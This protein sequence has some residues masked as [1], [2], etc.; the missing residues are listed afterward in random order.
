M[1]DDEDQMN[2]PDG[3]KG[4]FLC[5]KKK[6][7][8]V[9]CLNCAGVF[10]KSCVL[11]NKNYEVVSDSLI[12]C[13]QPKPSAEDQ[14][15]DNLNEASTYEVQKLKF[16]NL[17]LK[18]L[19]EASESKFQLLQNN[20]KLLEENKKLLEEKVVLIQKEFEINTKN[21]NKTTQ[22]KNHNKESYSKV[23]SRQTIPT[24]K[25]VNKQ[26]SEDATSQVQTNLK[27]TKDKEDNV[28]ELEAAQLNKMNDIINLV[29]EEKVEED[30]KTVTYRKKAKKHTTKFYGENEDNEFAIGRKVWLYLY[31][32][33]RHVTTEKIRKF[34]TDQSQFKDADIVIKEL[35][36]QETQNKCFMFGIDWDLRDD[37]YKPSTWPKS[38]AF[39][40]FDFK[41]YHN[42]QNQPTEDF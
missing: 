3:Q 1:A 24:K 36:T 18:K 33:K 12:K 25:T 16:E 17:M 2:D 9:V 38:M 5:C 41:K 14:I 11:R 13:C 19:L 34:I 21:I 27:P 15:L 8:V 31:R 42:Y 35:P 37:V 28:K 20:N 32:I 7:S 22:A 29:N 39:K 10:H 26:Q 30:F 40:R 6:C 4:A 23:T